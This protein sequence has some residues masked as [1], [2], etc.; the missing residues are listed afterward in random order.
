VSWKS[1]VLLLVLGCTA[2]ADPPL[3]SIPTTVFLV[4]AY[5]ATGNG[6]TDDTV[7]VQN[8]LTAAQNGGG[9]IVEFP[10]GTF[11]CGP[12]NVGGSTDMQLDA[13]ATL[14]AQPYGT[15]PLGGTVYTNFISITGNQVAITGTGVIDGQGAP[16]WAAYTA[17]NNIPHRPYLIKFTNCN[18]V[19]IANVTL[20]NSPMFHLAFAATN[21]VTVNNVTVSASATSPNTDACDPAGSHYLI[22]NCNFSDGDDNVAIKPQDV[23]CSDLTV[24]NCTIGAGHGISIGGETN[25]GLTGFTVSNCTFNGTTN[26]LRLKADATE[27]G[28]VTNVSYSNLTMTNVQYPIVFYSYYNQVG[29]P[30]ATS[31]SNQSTVAKAQLWNT[32]PP[33]SLNSSTLPTWQN[34]TLTNIVANRGT[35]ALGYNTVWGLPNAPFTNVTFNNVVLNGYS[36]TEIYNAQNVVFTGGTNLGT[37]LL[38]NAQVIPAL[39]RGNTITAGKTATFLAQTLATTANAGTTIQPTFQWSLNGQ[40]LS[41]GTRPDGASIAG[42]Q[43]ALLVVRGTQAAEGGSYS[44]AITDALDG[45]GTALLPGGNAATAVTPPATLSIT[46]GADTGRLLNL[47]ARGV[48]GT[49]SN[50][51]IGGF[52]V[53]PGANAST[54]QSLLVRGVGPS[55]AAFG[56]AN[57][58][59]DPALQVQAFPSGT[60]VAQNDNWGGNAAVVAAE[61]LTGAFPLASAASL[62]AALVAPFSPGAY[63]VVVTGPAS[64]IALVELYDAS[65]ASGAGAPQLINLSTRAVIGTGAN[66]LTAGWVIGGATARTV[67][68]RGVGPTLAAFGISGT[69]ADPQLTV[70]DSTGAAVATNDNWGGDTNVAAIATAVGAFPLA[71]AQSKD[72]A[73]VLTLAPGDYTALVS[74]VGT[75]TGTGMV[76]IYDVP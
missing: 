74:G 58:A 64:G 67:L 61:A 43:A 24:I 28:P 62:D 23:P 59:T 65:G 27:G 33:N 60:V 52:V 73:L 25:L 6:V 50:P 44:V 47:S 36:G 38:Y 35:A 15:Y 12:L 45:Y 66:T 53:H 8:A 21:Y 76:E 18:Y 11:L 37:L 49:G 4:T 5:G 16:W 69:I 54:T 30:G 32:T 63:S 22:E 72:A 29:T 19:L 71:S 14:L 3:P 57:A 39:P 46:G 48:S 31:G 34:I 40:P 2:R 75:A 13:G 26:G 55:I 70:Y 56:V 51:L 17:N 41:D 10:A 1:L 42:S 68:V 7:A 9:G 20:R